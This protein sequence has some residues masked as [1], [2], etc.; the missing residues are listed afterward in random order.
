MT[1]EQTVE[2]QSDRRLVLDLPPELPV[3]RARVAVTVTPERNETPEEH[4]RRSREA[5]ERCRGLGK[6]LGSQVTS[7]DV[8][9]SHREDLAREEA[10]YQRLYGKDSTSK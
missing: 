7:E 1:I 8:I 4:R 10:K 3:G 9:A 5:I 6:R 2:I